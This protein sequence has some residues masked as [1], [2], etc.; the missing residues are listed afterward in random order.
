M[1]I[2]I[3]AAMV[4]RRNSF[5]IILILTIGIAASNQLLAQ[6]PA[7]DNCS[8]AINIPIPSNGF[9]LGNFTS[10]QS[11]LTNATVQTSEAY[12]PAI[13]VAA[14]DKKSVWYKFSIPTIRAVRVTLTQPGTTITA[15]NAGFAVYQT[16]GCLPTNANISNKLTPI[17]TFGNTYHPCVPAGDY[18]IQVSSKVAANGPITIAIEI[19]DQTGAAYD[20]PNQ[21]YAFGVAAVNGRKID[22]DTECQSIEDA[23]EVCA[24]LFN[25][26]DYHKSAWFTFTTP[27]Y[28]DYLAVTLSGDGLTSYFP[29]GAFNVLKKFGY[30]LY[31]GNVVTT[32]YTT[33]PV[34]DGCDSM[35]TNGLQSAVQRYTC[36]DLQPNTTYSIQLF[37][38]K[39]FKDKLRLGLIT[40]GVAPTAAP[41]PV[42]GM[43]A[44]NALGILTAT[45][46]GTTN[47][48]FDYFGCNSRHS[49]SACGAAIPATSITFG[50]VKYN[51]SSFATFTLSGTAAI[52]FRPGMITCGPRPIIRLFKQSVT[53][54]CASLDTA[55]LVGTATFNTEIECL[56]PGNYV[57]QILGRD[58][59]MPLTSYNYFTP[60]YNYD[61]CLFTN[62]GSR[63]R[64]D[65]EVH[66]R[67]ASN[68]YSLNVKGAFDSINRVGSI[69]QPLVSGV[70]YKSMPDTIGC[71]P[72]LR[73]WDTTCSPL[74]DKIIYRQFVVADSGTVAFSDLTYS[75]NPPLR[76]R[77]YSGDANALATAQNIFTFPDKVT[78]IIPKTLC[79]DGYLYC[80]N[81]SACVVP[82]TYTFTTMGSVGD[83]G[84][85]DRPTFTFTKTRT[86][87]NSPFNAHNMGSIMDTLGPNGGTKR[88]A[89][90]FWS[91]EDN[92]V[93]IN[94]YTPCAIGGRPATKAIYRQFYLKDDAIV[95]FSNPG[96]G[97]WCVNN[98]YGIR[99]LFY[100]KATDGFTGLSPVG[101]QWN[102]FSS[103]QTTNNCSP[104]P[105]GWYTVVSYGTGPSYDS[106]TRLVNTGG[107]YNG[108]VSF[109]DEF[110]LTITPACPGPKFNRPYKASVAAGNTPHLIQW[111]TN[112]LNSTP[113]YPRTDTTY[114]LPVENFNCTLDTP[115]ASHPI[116]TCEATANR[117]A[118]YVF[119]T[120]A[121]SYIRIN[122]G[123]YFATVYDKDVR[124]DSLQFANAIPIQQCN[125]TL[126]AI[127]FCFF[128]PGTYTLVI[129]A[130]DANICKSVAPEIYIDQPGYSRFDYANKAYDFDVVPPDNVY[131]LGK[132]GDVN[133]LHPTR[134]PSNDF[135]YCTTGAF[136]TDPT[137]GVCNTKV[138]PNVYNSGPNKPLYDSAFPAG[139]DISRRNL[140]YTFVA[141][142][143]GTVRIKVQNKTVGRGLQPRFAVYKSDVDGNLPFSTVVANG[144]VDSTLAQGLSFVTMNFILYY[145]CFQA[146]DNISFYRDPCTAVP[147]RYY[148]LVENVNGSPN[149]VGGQLPNTQVEVSVLIDSVNLVLPKFDTYSQAGD[150]GTVGVGTFTGPTDNYSCAT[151]DATDPV[152]GTYGTCSKTL[153]YKFTPTVTGNVRYRIKVNNSLSNGYDQVQL[154]RQSKP[155]DSTSSGLNIQLYSTVNSANGT[156][157]QTCVSPGT[158]YLLLTG[159]SRVNEYVFPEIELIEAVGDFC[160]RAI[161]AAMSGP[162]A[163]SATALVN[164]HTIATD[165]GEF[166][167]QLTCPPGA[168]TSDYKSSWFRID[169]GGK[170]T[171]DVTAYLQENTNAS[172]SDIKYRLMTGDC[173]AMQEQS[174]VLDALTQNT[175]QCLAP[176]QSYYVQ[177]FTPVVKNFATV[178]GTID[179]KLSAILHADTCAPLANCLA[180]ANF[181]TAFNCST[182]DSVKF[183]NF[184]TYGTSITYKWDFGHNGQ[185]STAVSPSFFYPALP[186]AKTYT[187]KLVVTNTSCLQKDS[188][189]RQIT[190]PGRPYINLGADINQCN[191]SAPITLK[192][193]SHPGATYLWQNN[194]AVDSFRV[195]ATGNNTYWVRV[196]YNGC[197]RRDTIRVLIS[198]ISAKPLQQIN[199]CI[200][201]VL[202][203]VR[204]GFG[205]TYRW[206]TGA[207]TQSVYM[208]RPGYY[209]ADITYFN[210]VYRDSFVVNNVN[211]IKPFGNDTTVCLSKGGII[212]DANLTG[213]ISYTWQNN[214]TADTLLVTAPG[215]YRVAINFGNCT[216]RDTI[217]ISGFPAPLTQ[218]T[219]TSI[220]YGSFLQLPWG[221]DTNVGGTYRDTLPYRGGCDSLIRIVNLTLKAKPS[222]GKDTTICFSQTGYSLNATTAGAVSY[223]WQ[224]GKTGPVYSLNLPGLYWVQVNYG[225]CSTRDSVVINDFSAPVVTTVDTAICTG[226]SL[227]LP[228]GQIISN[229]GSYSDTLQSFGGGCDSLIRVYNI[230]VTPKPALGN[231]AS[232]SICKGV[233]VDLTTYFNSTGLTTN[234]TTNNSIVTNPTSVNVA[235]TYRLIATTGNRC[236][237]T[238]LV[239]LTVINKPALGNDST[240]AIC[241]GTAANLYAVFNTTGLTSGWTINGTPVLSPA[242][243][244]A[245]GSYQLIAA[246][247]SSCADTALLVL[248]VNPKP[249]LGPDS[250]ITICSGDT[251]NLNTIFNSTGLNNAWTL[252]NVAV[253][254]PTSIA[255]A[256][257]YRMVASAAAGCS[258]TAL[259]TIT[260]HTKPVVGND[261]VRN[262][263]QGNTFDL[264]TAFS[265]TGLSVA[266]T[267]GSNIVTSPS[268]VSIAGAY[269][270]IATNNFGCSDTS[271]L[272]LSISPKPIL[273]NDTAI[274]RCNGQSIN[275]T[276]FYTTNN[277]TTTWTFGGTTVTNPAL[278]A[279]TGVYQLIAAS[280]GGCT[281][282]TLV[283]LTVNPKPAIGKDTLIR[284]CGNNVTNLTSLYNTS[285]LITSW[286]LN[287]TIVNNPTAISSPGAYQLVATNNFGCSDTSLLTLSISPKPFLGN[288]TAISRCNGQGINL[289]N[290]YTTNNLATTWTFGGAPVTN[291]VQVSTKGAYQL[292]AT[293]LAGC[294]DTVLVNLT[295][296]PKPAIGNDTLIRICGNNL[297][298][299]TLLYNTSGLIPSWTLNGTL[300]N[301]PTAISLAGAYRLIVTNNFG[302]SDT[303]A[304]TLSVNP[305]PT[306][307]NDTTISICQ[308]SNQNLTT[309]FTTIG[310]SSLWTL[311]GNIIS[312]PASVN[313][314]GIYQLIANN[315]F[316]C[317]D[318]A[319]LTLTIS[320]KQSIGNDTTI[321]I[322]PGSTTNLTSL[323]NTTGLSSNWSLAGNPVTNPSAINLSGTYQLITGNLISC[324]DTAFV[325]VTILP[326]PNAGKD[327]TIRICTGSSFN[328][329]ALYNTG[330]NITKWSFNGIAVSNPAAVSNPGTYQ[331]ITTSMAGCVDTVF[332][333]MMVV[334]NPLLVIN[335]PAAICAPLTADLTNA[336]ITNG[337]SSNLLFSYFTDAAA[338]IPVNNP[339]TAI[340]GR[341]YIKGTN[342]TGC[343][344]VKPV[345]ITYYAIPFVNA[346][347]DVVICDKDSTMLTATVTN[348]TAPVSYLWEPAIA[349]EIKNPTAATT[350]VKPSGTQRYIVAIRDS[351]GCNFIVRDTVWVTMQ[352]PVPAFAG[353]DTNVI[354][355]TP[356]QLQASGGISYTWSPGSVLNNRFIANPTATLFRDSTMLTVIVKDMAGCIGYDTIWIKA[357]NGIKYYVPNAFS[358][359]GDGLNDVFRPI[360]V[361]I[362]STELFR[363]FN[364]YGELVFETSQWMKGWDGLWKGRAQPLG[365]YIWILKG[366]DRNG[367]TIE[368]K[369]NVMLIR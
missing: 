76:Y 135:F 244:T 238:A 253:S 164:C 297:T 53:S 58:D 243:V 142:D 95:R 324:P 155:G 263:C 157:A 23:T 36:G 106:T 165:Y 104:L 5:L 192:A 292:T 6:A 42:A 27:A 288:D 171:L 25:K 131:H 29:S 182:T 159:C 14:L 138:N 93:P 266:W 59:P 88:G 105:A 254:N 194:S 80:E 132:T 190:I 274:S 17:V 264:N 367:K 160:G 332:V 71:L 26:Q 226:S 91:C 62:L 107:R 233:S 285:G 319:L 349:G 203:N 242:A 11:D 172:S 137:N 114:N 189:T 361:G 188:V 123:G 198:P 60:T 167:P 195:T 248:S 251:I 261:L 354:V 250:T 78:G 45:A 259:L 228:W 82:G 158:Y 323:Y 363:I 74:N 205:E 245:A 359:N 213:A 217:Q 328:V 79:M 337:S 223:E 187:V 31:K 204:R 262:I 64:L 280:L 271:L 30:T 218:V 258:D 229:T 47:T 327:T 84:R 330:N 180:N 236:S 352:P 108:H 3:T 96:Y 289:T 120:T 335:N 356:H 348:N 275:L 127:Q 276:N 116:K 68:K 199:L 342:A 294:T 366:K 72:T 83:V 299:L 290:L 7:N 355:N 343:F 152:Y 268:A 41:L 4:K 22:F 291:P 46:A 246:N 186:V 260:Y 69:Q 140:W 40:G 234:W 70:P 2:N 129:F 81:K 309:V 169:I 225:T 97:G 265:T 173:G 227:V 39:D 86:K 318:T 139:F 286:T 357:F 306:V 345:V 313:T 18:L 144:A 339:A 183:I 121:V 272:T 110:D 202:V 270:L 143:A 149:E 336:A 1:S 49:V 124:K 55:N 52:R 331:L 278:V 326:K 296:N 130:K 168:K 257:V 24:A 112:R 103:A 284:I 255:A 119:R 368:M 320:P 311:N 67:K 209:W 75:N 65:M 334:A 365:N 314:P 166:G 317:A 174:C 279:N 239:Q 305:K 295:V 201:S 175:Y 128:Q 237:D 92:A 316:N 15:G 151:R 32:S 350:N 57:V 214:S 94:G 302:C 283:N 66:T 56:A 145:Y 51:L 222:V 21:A 28:L 212:L 231:D 308:G 176:G 329:V 310:V 235:G 207:T 8:N 273:G 141:N 102:C 358:P 9:G 197:S 99:T 34:V 351:Y 38:H 333:S 210:C 338:T 181:D 211:A 240:I 369:G 13:F 346:G 85:A 252:N 98:A 153:W 12:A 232:V 117:V 77:L 277:L 109:W 219:D 293:S 179:L 154:F 61:Q 35:Q 216:I 48:M 87:H 344:D 322:C 43:P 300:V 230:T 162:G 111:S 315:N 191:S 206:N 220:C 185:T 118:Y 364:R 269:Q 178:T 148:V 136:T 281:D 20:H 196:T 208:S 256:G 115:F 301:N 163:V 312:N 125:S 63:F 101:N 133:P 113:A 126:G 321:N 215:Q 37:F 303:A 122:T 89:R 341:Y 10:L 307:G 147:T 50:G 134:A 362:A 340:G 224:D 170:D 54:N 146:L 100:G 247:N 156:W 353:N 287:S 73:P 150:F 19:S 249:A 304:A 267:F 325:T 221:T 360:P 177:V 193:T 16:N 44:S 184:S 161:P 33:L 90:D 282:T 298:N 347:P 241:S 200:D